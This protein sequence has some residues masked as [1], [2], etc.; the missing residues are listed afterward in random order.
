[1]M[2][3]IKLAKNYCPISDQQNILRKVQKPILSQDRNLWTTKYIQAFCVSM[4]AHDFTETCELV[5]I[6]LLWRR[7]LNSDIKKERQK[8]NNIYIDERI[9]RPDEK[10]SNQI[11]LGL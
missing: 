6:L 8:N 9:S 4:K 5:V 7:I 10:G 2:T 3:A 1:M 11:R